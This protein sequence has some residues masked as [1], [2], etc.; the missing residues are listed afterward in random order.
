MGPNDEVVANTKSCSDVTSNTF[1]RVIEITVPEPYYG[2]LF[3]DLLIDSLIY[4][5]IA[6]DCGILDYRTE[7][8]TITQVIN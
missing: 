4:S 7:I 2:N 5:L 1:N 8:T 3:I 6:R